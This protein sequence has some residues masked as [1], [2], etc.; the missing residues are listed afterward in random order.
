ML[1]LFKTLDAD[2]LD[3]STILAKQKKGKFRGFTYIEPDEAKIA[4]E[5]QSL[6]MHQKEELDNVPKDDGY[7]TRL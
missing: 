3:A 5:M 4:R 7:I 1:T 6:Q 2:S